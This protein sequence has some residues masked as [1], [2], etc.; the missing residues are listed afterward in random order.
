MKRM[1][2]KITLTFAIMFVVGVIIN[3][4]YSVISL[5]ESFFSFVVMASAMLS[6]LFY[7]VYIWINTRRHKYIALLGLFCIGLFVIF[8]SYSSEGS[9]GAFSSW[10][11]KDTVMIVYYVIS[12]EIACWQGKKL[13]EEDKE[14]ISINV[15]L[16]GDIKPEDVE[17]TI[18]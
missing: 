1:E 7:L 10:N 13:L 18:E 17:V 2:L 9:A 4:L 16:K 5:G 15:T 8:A 3:G 11:W 14:S 12:Y 6:A